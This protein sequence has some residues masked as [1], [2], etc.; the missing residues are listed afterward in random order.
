ME[1][2]F[3]ASAHIS[4]ESEQKISEI[5][6]ELMKNSYSAIEMQNLEAAYWTLLFKSSMGPTWH[7]LK[8]RHLLL[9]SE[10]Y[11]ATA[12]KPFRTSQVRPTEEREKN[13]TFIE[14]VGEGMKFPI[15]FSVNDETIHVIFMT[16]DEIL[17]WPKFRSLACAHFTD[18]ESR[19]WLFWT[20]VRSY[21]MQHKFDLD[22][23]VYRKLEHQQ[24][25]KI[26]GIALCQKEYRKHP[27]FAL[28]FPD[29]VDKM[30]TMIS[31]SFIALC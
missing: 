7:I 23:V 6:I 18:F 28:F 9:F 4:P 17:D 31:D 3:S 5:S 11:N 20:I 2:D 29:T 25:E 10:V 26:R 24:A 22:G 21:L 16:A 13:L 8:A 27:L 1:N 30:V 15:T 12:F 19:S 14:R